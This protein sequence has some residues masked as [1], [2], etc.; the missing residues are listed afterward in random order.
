MDGFAGAVLLSNSVTAAF[1]VV[2]VIVVEVV[3]GMLVVVVRI[4]VVLSAGT[5]PFLAVLSCT[6]VVVVVVRGVPNPKTV[7]LLSPEGALAVN[8][9][10]GTA[11]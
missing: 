6:L 8:S 9:P 1:V 5:L 3:A 4:V 7:V 10:A 11:G 2:V